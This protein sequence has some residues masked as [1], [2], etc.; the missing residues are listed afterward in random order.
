MEITARMEYAT[1]ALVEMAVHQSTDGPNGGRAPLH[2]S[3]IA[4]RQGIPRPYLDQLLLALRRAGLVRSIRGP[5]GGHLLAQQAADVTLR[6]VYLAL[7]GDGEARGSRRRR[8]RGKAALERALAATWD[9]VR[10]RFLE[11]L[12]ETTIDALAASARRT[13]GDSMYYI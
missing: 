10:A 5:K 9:R 12:S 11:T 7:E 13:G 6:E 4:D 3:D 1:L 8:E 2:A